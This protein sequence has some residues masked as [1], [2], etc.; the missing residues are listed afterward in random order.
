[1]YLNDLLVCNQNL[2]ETGK[3]IQ[4]FLQHYV[5]QFTTVM[6]TTHF[7]E[8]LSTFLVFTS[9][10]TTRIIYLLCKLILTASDGLVY[11]GKPMLLR[12]SL[13]YT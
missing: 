5:I 6:C 7:Y 4:R 1:M 9:S 13:S 10:P 12:K 3:R 2:F 8:N 11:P